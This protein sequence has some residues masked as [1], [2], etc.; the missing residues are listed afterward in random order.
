MPPYYAINL[1]TGKS[2]SVLEVINAF[3]VASEK[4][5]SYVFAPRRPGD[6]ACYYADSTLLHKL[7]GWQAG[8]D[9]EH[10]FVV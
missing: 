10:M 8:S 6:I 4:G 9:L 7:L 1:G 3:R 5:I 2:S